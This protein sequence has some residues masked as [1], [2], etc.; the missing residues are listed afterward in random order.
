METIVESDASSDVSDVPDD[1][2]EQAEERARQEREAAK[3]EEATAPEDDDKAADLFFMLEG[4]NW[5]MLKPDYKLVFYDN[6]R[7]ATGLLDIRDPGPLPDP[8]ESR[9]APGMPS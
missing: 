5:V 1:L 4:K 3:I 7:R 9:L 8:D 2:D 6:G